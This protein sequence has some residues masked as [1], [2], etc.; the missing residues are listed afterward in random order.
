MRGQSLAAGPHRSKE[1]PDEE[2]HDY[3][4]ECVVSSRQASIRKGNHIL[5]VFDEAGR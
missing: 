5:F 4:E 2:G 1:D 3:A